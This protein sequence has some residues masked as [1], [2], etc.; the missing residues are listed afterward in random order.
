[1]SNISTV[2]YERIDKG[3]L[4]EAIEHREYN[5][6]LNERLK[7]L[8]KDAVVIVESPVENYLQANIS[9]VKSMLDNGFEGVYLSF[10]RPFKNIS[11][12][13]EK[14]GIDLGKLFVI[15]FATAFSNSDQEINSRCVNVGPDVKVEDMVNTICSSLEK[16]SQD[17]RFVFVDS[18]ST[19]ALHEEFSETMRFSEFLINT[20]RKN[21]IND[22]IFVFNVAKDLAKRRY[23]EN[24][25]V[26]ANEHIHLG[27]CT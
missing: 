18:L 11:G 3:N 24:I 15:D 12:L 4:I 16:L 21:K 20:I 17:K 19:F 26:Y 25:S 1:M 7:D 6:V 14:E 27:L 10:Q 5:R 22:V 9:S 13:F 2:D 8:D 23:I